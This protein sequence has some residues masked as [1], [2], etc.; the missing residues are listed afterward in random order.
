MTSESI[1]LTRGELETL[2][3]S[4]VDRRLAAFSE[5]QATLSRVETQLAELRQQVANGGGNVPEDRVSLVVFSGELDPLF[6]AFTIAAGAASM[7]MQVSMF[8]TFWGLN[9]LRV[10]RRFEG[11]NL[12]EKMVAAM[13]PSGPDR[14]GTTR[15]NMGGFGPMFFQSLMRQRGIET[16]PDMIDLAAEM[17]VRMVACET[18]MKVMGVAR[19][20]LWS[21]IDFGGVATFL[22]DASRSKISLYI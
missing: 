14:L 11:K 15:L 7:G 4:A 13:M 2:I 12:G 3:E 5:C 8:F 16:V 20:E 6:A 9:A 1:T 19:S 21:G 22:E 17:G 10:G 18:S